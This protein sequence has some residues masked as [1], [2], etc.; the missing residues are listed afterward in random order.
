MRWTREKG[1][2]VAMTAVPLSRR[3][4]LAVA[5][6]GTA[7]VLGAC[8]ITASPVAPA[9]TPNPSPVAPGPYLTHRL[10][11]GEELGT[12]AMSNPI[13]L[14]QIL[15]RV[16]VNPDFNMVCQNGELVPS[17]GLPA[18]VLAAVYYPYY[19][20]GTDHRVP[21]PNPLD[22]R[23]GP[24]PVLFYAHGYRPP[25]GACIVT[26]PL[27]RDF[28]TVDAMLSHVASY[29]C[30]CVVPDLSWLPGGYP[31]GSTELQYAYDLR[32]T[33]LSEYYNYLIRLNT[34]LFA[35]QLDLSR[36]VFVGHSTGGGAAT[37]AGRILS[38]VLNQGSLAYCLIAPVDDSARSD[39]RNLLV[40]RGGRDTLQVRNAPIGVYNASGTPKTLVTI[41]GANHF[42]YTDLCDAN[43]VCMPYG[44]NDPMG[45]ISRADQQAAGAAYLAAMVRY[46][47]LGDVTMQ[48][49]LTGAKEVEGLEA[50]GITIQSAGFRALPLQSPIATVQPSA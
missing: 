47:A 4:F 45:S 26:S 35:Q 6:M 16:T 30:V 33:V 50:L 40:L 22:L 38:P 37:H 8:N 44:I 24:Y 48:P 14:N 32:A 49:Y 15:R 12:A 43:N 34:T 17:G 28:T 36:V 39:D 3:Q 2:V 41:P 9:S 10:I 18:Q 29:G 11:L 5:G 21:T 25:S 19:G 23:K 13:T 20:N 7:A 46:H 27:N 42:G 31:A 1:V